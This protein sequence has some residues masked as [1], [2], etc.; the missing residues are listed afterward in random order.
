MPTRA[1][2]L[3]LVAAVAL[4]AVAFAVAGAP[5]RTGCCTAL[6]TCTYNLDMLTEHVE[7]A[8]QLLPED[9]AARVILEDAL[10]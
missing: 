6:D 4:L 5:R 10:R 7:E 1:C 8:I 2:R 9:H 3:L